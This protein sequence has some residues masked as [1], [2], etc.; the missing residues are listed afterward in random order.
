VEPFKE[1]LGV[2]A[3][4]RIARAM[5]RAK[6]DFPARRFLSGIESE[7]TP[8]ELKD[9]MRA[10]ARR[11]GEAMPG[12]PLRTFPAL[13]D[14]LRTGDED[15]VGLEGFAVWPLTQLVADRGLAHFEPSMSAL[16]AMTRVFTAEFA[17]RPFLREHESRTLTRLRDWCEEPDEHVRRLASEG[18]RPLLPWAERLHRLLADPE[19][20]WP[21]LAALR[22]DPSE[23][24]RRSVANHLN[25]HSKRYPDWVV[26]RLERWRAE[27]ATP[28][29]E[30]LIRHATRTLIKRGHV[31]AL[32][33]QGVQPAKVRTLGHQVLTPVVRL[34]EELRVEVRIENDG[35]SPARVI[36]DHALGLL[37]ADGSAGDRVFKGRRIELGPGEVRTLELRIPLR[38]VTTRRHYAGPQ[39]WAPVVNG[40]RGDAR[41][42]ELRLR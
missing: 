36:I 16:R 32:A 18:S 12:E 29:R 31:A 39:T 13:V 42:F 14:A 40:V 25:D 5:R 3:A 19:L 6:G 27:G 33:L 1:L 21:I 22:D 8:L 35:Y 41:S 26:S 4:R 20:S 15:R 24:V 37:R 9:R 10:I 11:L 17:I 2:A 23:Y 30:R 34:G 38:P 28:E 7:L